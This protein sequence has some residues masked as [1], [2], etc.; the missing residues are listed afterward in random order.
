MQTVTR[1]LPIHWAVALING[2]ETG[3]SDEEFNQFDKFC[4]SMSDNYRSWHCLS[5]SEDE[6]FMRWHDAEWFGVGACQVADF[7]FVVTE[8]SYD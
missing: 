1:C 6:Q 5:V 4:E 8:K 2:D 7:T 3:L